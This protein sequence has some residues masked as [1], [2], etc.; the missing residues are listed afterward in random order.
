MKGTV[1]ES[2]RALLI[3]TL[4]S[5]S[6][7]KEVTLQAWVDTGFTG[8]LILPQSM[9]DELNLSA[10]GVIEAV[11]AD[12]SQ[13]TLIRYTCNLPWF[14]EIH[15]LEVVANMGPM[16][17]IGIGLLESRRLL[18]DYKMRTTELD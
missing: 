13:V 12:G 8:D 4:M 3:L 15:Q 11:L 18:I 2:G 9:V 16:P 5:S 14:G 10:T 17:L 6:G 7:D 1:D